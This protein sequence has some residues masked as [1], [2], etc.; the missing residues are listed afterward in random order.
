MTNQSRLPVCVPIC[1]PSKVGSMFAEFANRD[2]TWEI[3]VVSNLISS[4]I[5]QQYLDRVLGK[6]PP[7]YGPHLRKI[8]WYWNVLG[9]LN[10]VYGMNTSPKHSPVTPF[11]PLFTFQRCTMKKVGCQRQSM[12]YIFE[13]DN[14]VPMMCKSSK[15]QVQVRMAFTQKKRV[16]K[17]SK[18]CPFSMKFCSTYIRYP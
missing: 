10:S 6:F 15:S 18:S 14:S 1:R 2:L 4:G 16:Q 7:I 5:C 17:Q 11:S 3:K 13:A 8:K 12:L 9:S